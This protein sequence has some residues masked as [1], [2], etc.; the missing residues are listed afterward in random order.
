MR[1]YCMSLPLTC[2]ANPGNLGLYRLYQR[3]NTLVISNGGV[4]AKRNDSIVGVNSDSGN[5]NSVLVTG[6]NSRWS[7]DGTVTVGPGSYGNS[8]VISNGGAVTCMGDFSGCGTIGGTNNSARVVDGGLWQST[9]SVQ[10]GGAV[11][12]YGGLNNSLVI[13]GGTVQVSNLFVACNNLIELD[14]GSVLA[15][16]ASKTASVEVRGT[17]VFSG[18]VLQAD[19]LVITNPCASVRSHRRD[20]DR[21]QRGS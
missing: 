11:A 21:R 12:G 6:P 1:L 14:S 20:T 3:R 15:T 13:D 4:V 5:D 18:G 7:N 2:E 10:I 8:L 16:N 19:T 9:G 17:L